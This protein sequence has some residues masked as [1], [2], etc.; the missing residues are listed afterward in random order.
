[1]LKY[2]FNKV[3]GMKTYNLNKKRF[4]HRHFPVNI[5]KLLRTP[6]FKNICERLLQFCYASETTNS[7]EIEKLKLK[8]PFQL[9]SNVGIS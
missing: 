9:P 1:M 8:F 6:V 3:V 2:L 4:Q 7:Q 5:V